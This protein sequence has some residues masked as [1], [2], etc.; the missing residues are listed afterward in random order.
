MAGRAGRFDKVKFSARPSSVSTYGHL[1]PLRRCDLTPS[2]GATLP[3]ALLMHQEANKPR[4]FCFIPEATAMNT[5]DLPDR[6]QSRKCLQQPDADIR[7]RAGEKADA[8][9]HH[10]DAH[11]ALDIGELALHARE[12]F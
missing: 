12:Q 2:I 11:G 8:G 1:R 10:Q 9:D 7:D 6:L 3:R 4:G 5:L